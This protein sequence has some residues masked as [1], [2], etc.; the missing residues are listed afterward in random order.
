MKR[1]CDIAI[2]FLLACTVLLSCGKENE[3]ASLPE[4]PKTIEDLRGH[5]IAI[6]TGTLQE[7]VLS[8]MGYGKDIISLSGGVPELLAS[9]QSGTAEFFLLDS[10]SIIGSHIDKLGIVPLFNSE[11]SGPYGFGIRKTDGDLREQLNSYIREIK[12]DGRYDA[13]YK[14]WFVGDIENIELAKF[15]YKPDGKHLTIGISVYYP[16]IFMKDRE[17]TG[18]ELEIL[19]GFA[20]QYGYVPDILNA[21][22]SALI[23]ALVSEKIDVI[24]GSMFITDERKMSIDFSEPYY[25]AFT[26]CFAMGEHFFSGY[27]EHEKKGLHDFMTSVGI[28]FRRNFIEEERWIIV[29]QGLWETIVI[30][31]WSILFGALFGCFVCALMFSGS[32]L[33]RRCTDGFC[34]FIG[35]VPVL[36]LL[37]VM[38][39]IVFSGSG[40]SGRVV[41]IIAFAIN[42][43]CSISGVYYSGIKAIDRGQTEAGL[44][45]GFKPARTFTLFVLPQALKQIL[46]LFKGEAVSLIKNTSI[47][48]YIAIQDLTKASDIIRSRTFDAFFPLIA[49]SIVYFILAWAFGR[50]LDSIGKTS[51]TL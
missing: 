2:S 48:G 36:V 37:M 51:K 12:A 16:F 50:I 32:R 7:L 41:A 28:S 11:P 9:I 20:E 40:I 44:A 18:F 45:L 13:L 21:D 4:P 35:G 27:G 6:T 46:P 15:N 26:S 25:T 49:I 34:S 38:F 31:L 1:I 5:K 43:G 14:R 3:Q 10:C 33:V 24:A 8:E 17:W 30:S 42:F 22:F 19:Y 29:L 47:V 23:P 39:Y